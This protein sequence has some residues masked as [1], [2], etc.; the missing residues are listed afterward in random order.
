MVMA[1]QIRLVRMW[2][3]IDQPITCRVWQ[4]MTVARYS[5]PVQVRM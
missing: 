5:Q 4:S 1:S 2:V 3:A